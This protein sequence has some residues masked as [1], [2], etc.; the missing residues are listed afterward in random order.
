MVWWFC[1]KRRK[2]RKKNQINFTYF[3]FYFNEYTVIYF[4]HFA[5]VSEQLI[6][7]NRKEV[8]DN[9]ELN[10]TETFNTILV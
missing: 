2:K 4:S 8:I 6:V 9:E 7:C 1:K 5:T 3:A 10:N